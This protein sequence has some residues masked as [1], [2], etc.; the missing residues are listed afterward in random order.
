MIKGSG[1]SVSIAITLPCNM[2]RELDKERGQIPR[3]SFIRNAVETYWARKT[4]QS[5]DYESQ[6]DIVKP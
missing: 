1:T 3:S 4:Q 2:V 5:A 6:E